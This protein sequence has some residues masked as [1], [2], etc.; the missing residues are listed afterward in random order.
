MAVQDLAFEDGMR[1]TLRLCDWRDAG[2]VFVA[3][4]QVDDK[5]CCG[6]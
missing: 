4:G 3:Q 6:V 1:A 5:V 2:L